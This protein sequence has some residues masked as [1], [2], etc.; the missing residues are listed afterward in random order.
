MNVPSRETKMNKAYTKQQTARHRS[1]TQ[2]ISISERNNH[3]SF[4]HNSSFIYSTGYVLCVKL[5]SFVP[6]QDL[7]VVVRCPL[8]HHNYLFVREEAT[9]EKM[10][11]LSKITR[12][13][14]RHTMMYA[15]SSISCLPHPLPLSPIPAVGIYL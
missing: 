14:P 2:I 4:S 3:F 9:E 7:V 15:S 11:N 8:C 12:F 10:F 13:I 1:V 6:F 5:N